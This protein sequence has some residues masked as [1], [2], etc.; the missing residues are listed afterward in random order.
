ML[1]YPSLYRIDRRKNGTVSQVPST[2]PL[3]VSFRQALTGEKLSEWLDLVSFVLSISL[4][5]SEDSFIWN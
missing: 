3:N 2:I 5:D 1:R 4:N